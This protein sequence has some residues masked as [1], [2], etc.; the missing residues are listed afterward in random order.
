MN[1]SHERLLLTLQ[2]IERGMGEG[3]HIGAQVYVSLGGRVIADV[4]LG[5]ARP[6]VAMTPDTLMLWLSAGKPLAA[7]AM[8]QLREQGRLDWDDPVARHIPEFAER[9][10][11]RVTIRQVLTHTGG[12]RGPVTSNW[13]LEPWE[14][15]IGRICQS[16]LEPGW[17]PGQRA[18]YH[19]ASGWY[20]LGEIV[21][22]HSGRTFDEYVRRHIFEP[23]GM[24]DSHFALSAEQYRNLGD[25]A[26]VLYNTQHQPPRAN[27]WDTVEQAAYERP[28]ASAR[29]PVRDLGRFYEMLLNQGRGLAGLVLEPESVAELTSRQRAGMLDQ[30]FKQVVDWGLGFIVNTPRADWQTVPYHFGPGASAGSYGHGGSQ[31]SIGFADPQRKL[32]VGIVLNGTPGEVKHHQRMNRILAALWEEIRE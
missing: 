6:G 26:G 27:R 30:T 28:G 29:G 12:F 24:G 31:S 22:R 17:V 1:L 14:Q 13:D 25:R 8:A 3:L 9:G 5:E 10:K 18:G 21:R 4:G 11:Q 32:A 23:A 2:A 15:I 19:V 20:V 7:V 16:P